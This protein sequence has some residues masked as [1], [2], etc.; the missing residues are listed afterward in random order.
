MKIKANQIAISA[1]GRADA[2]E[3]ALL[4]SAGR[5]KKRGGEKYLVDPE[6]MQGVLRAREAR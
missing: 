4:L 1:S 3:W 6:A 2:P 5:P